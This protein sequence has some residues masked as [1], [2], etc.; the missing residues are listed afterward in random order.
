MTKV[1]TKLATGGISQ[2]KRCDGT[3]SMTPNP[4]S[5]DAASYRNK[6]AASNRLS[7]GLRYLRGL[8]VERWTK[9]RRHT[10]ETLGVSLLRIGHIIPN[11]LLVSHS[12]SARA[13]QGTLKSNN[14]NNNTIND[15]ILPITI[16]SPAIAGCNLSAVKLK[17]IPEHDRARHHQIY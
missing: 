4:P 13:A 7:S 3:A 1:E 12:H 10:T 14:N 11:K 16:S 2:R 5:A 17:R 9:T 6:I 15:H 8:I